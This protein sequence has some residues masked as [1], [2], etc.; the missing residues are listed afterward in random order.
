M[1]DFWKRVKER[2]VSENTTQ[3]WVSKQTGKS[4]NTFKGWISKGILPNCIDSVKM[5]KSLNTTVEELVDGEKGRE[6]VL[7]WAGQN[8]VQWRP[9]DRL[10]KML[11]DLL[12]VD[13]TFLEILQPALTAA[14]NKKRMRMSEE[15]PN[16]VNH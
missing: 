1:M 11:D 3:A 15:I 5:A 13:D 10:E 16:V 7:K 4:L 14:V 8:G 9:P 12:F 6:Y 2:I